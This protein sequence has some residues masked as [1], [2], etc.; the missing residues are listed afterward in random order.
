VQGRRVE[1]AKS[2][3]LLI[4]PTGSGKTLL[5]QTLARL[6][7]VPFVIADATTLTEGRLMSARTSRTLSRSCCRNAT[8]TSKRR[9][10]ASCIIDE[11]DKISRKVDNPSITRDVSGRGRAAGAFETDRGTIASVPP[12]GGRK[13]PEPGIRAGRYHQHPVRLRRLRSTVWKKSF[14]SGRQDGIAF[15]AEVLSPDDRERECV[16]CANASGGLDQV[17]LIPSCGRLPWSHARGG[18][19]EAVRL[20]PG[21]AQTA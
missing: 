20:N 4:G 10:G 21:P 13:H 19:E 11:I 14:A 6:L 8:T 18:W 3:I 12:Q 15:G 7:D 17:R 5:A 2:K 9:S 1:L 16:V